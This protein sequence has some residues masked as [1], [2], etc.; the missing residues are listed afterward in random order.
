MRGRIRASAA[1][2]A[3]NAKQEAKVSFIRNV[4][5]V[6]SLG[7]ETVS[8]NRKIRVSALR[9]D[10]STSQHGEPGWPPSSCTHWE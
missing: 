5:V 4:A 6:L 10:M 9:S 3:T 7:P 2:R 8:A 1:G